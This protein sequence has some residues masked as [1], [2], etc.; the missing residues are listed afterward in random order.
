ME[1]RTGQSCKYHHLQYNQKVARHPRK[2]NTSSP[3]KRGSS[4]LL[5]NKHFLFQQKKSTGPA[6]ETKT[7]GIPATGERHLPLGQKPSELASL[8]RNQ[9]GKLSTVGIHCYN[10]LSANQN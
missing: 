9:M 4:N 8:R 2:R 3:R 10:P 6:L 7:M 1:K 5:K